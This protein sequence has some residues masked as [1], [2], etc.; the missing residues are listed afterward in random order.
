MGF[1]ETFFTVGA[2]GAAV[3]SGISVTAFAVNW[4]RYAK[5]EWAKNTGISFLKHCYKKRLQKD[6]AQKKGYAG[7]YELA[8]KL[9][10]IKGN[11]KVLFNVLIPSGED[12]TTELDAVMVHETGVYV[13]ENKNYGGT[14]GCFIKNKNNQKVLGNIKIDSPRWDVVY[15]S[16]KVRALYNPIMQN[17]MHLHFIKRLLGH[18]N[19]EPQNFFSYVTFDENCKIKGAPLSYNLSCDGCILRSSQLVEDANF[20]I[21]VRDVVLS[22]SDIKAISEVLEPYSRVSAQERKGHIERVAQHVAEEDALTSDVLEVSNDTVPLSEAIRSAEDKL[23]EQNKEPEK[24]PMINYM[25]MFR[26]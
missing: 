23:T 24:V 8:R 6:V 22:P 21:G 18:L 19:L 13:F 4:Y 7:E 16:G 9:N 20:K 1:L 26:S 25:N 15:K 5:S 11:K 14:V 2:W 10:R 3:T 12:K 17:E